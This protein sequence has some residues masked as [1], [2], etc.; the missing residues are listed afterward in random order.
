MKIFDFLF[1]RKKPPPPQRPLADFVPNYHYWLYREDL[2][3]PSFTIDDI[4]SRAGG[5]LPRKPRYPKPGEVWEWRR[6]L[7]HEFKEWDYPVQLKFDPSVNY[8][9]FLFCGCL[10]F[11]HDG[12]FR[13]T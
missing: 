9:P 4:L 2:V 7:S 6:C 1:R 12:T 13:K 10:D 11:V 8:W 5:K 3:N